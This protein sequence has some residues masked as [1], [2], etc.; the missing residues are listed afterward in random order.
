M[1]ERKNVAK[2]LFTR[3]KKPTVVM[4]NGEANVVVKGEREY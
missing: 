3:L 4:P 2:G 1:K